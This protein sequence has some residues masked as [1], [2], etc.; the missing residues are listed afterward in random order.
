MA[1][2]MIQKYKMEEGNMITNEF[3]LKTHQ[4]PA[5]R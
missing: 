2:T 3:I 4:L 1:L 5:P